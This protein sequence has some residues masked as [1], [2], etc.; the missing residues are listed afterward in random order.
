M[1]C[2]GY[3]NISKHIVHTVVLWSFFLIALLPLYQT[4]LEEEDPQ[5]QTVPQFD[6]H[7]GYYQT[8]AAQI[9]S[10]GIEQR[11]D[12]QE[13]QVEPR[14]PSPSPVTSA[15]PSPAAGTAQPHDS[16]CDQELMAPASTSDTEPE[17]NNEVL[18]R[19]F[20]FSNILMQKS[21]LFND[22]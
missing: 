11:D 5:T 9:I 20:F 7:S 16:H 2:N 18:I 10:N 17:T 15:P 12:A 4:E 3:L 6:N 14:Q 19:M 1:C 22:R 8:Q 13:N 21:T